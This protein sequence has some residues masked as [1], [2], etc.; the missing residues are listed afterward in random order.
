MHCDV[1]WVEILPKLLRIG[2]S[3]D[4]VNIEPWFSAWGLLHSLMAA[5]WISTLASYSLDQ[6]IKLV[7]RCIY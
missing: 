4:M 7:E 5:P 3:V 6:D 1:F 2:V